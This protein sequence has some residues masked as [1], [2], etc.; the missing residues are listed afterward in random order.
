MGQVVYMSLVNGMRVCESHIKQVCIPVGC[1]RP[2]VARVSQHALRRGEGS[3][4]GGVSAPGVS[5][6][7]GGSALGGVP[8]GGVYSWGC[9]PTCTEADT[10]PPL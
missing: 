4:L 2:L 7:A 10:P 6:L 1:V 9:I 3:G 5:A 8:L